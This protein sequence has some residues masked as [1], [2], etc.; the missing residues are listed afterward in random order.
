[1][2]TCLCSALNPSLSPPHCLQG[3]AQIPKCSPQRP[4]QPHSSQARHSNQTHPFVPAPWYS[5]STCGSS[6]LKH[7]SLLFFWLMPWF[8]KLR[9]PLSSFGSLLWVSRN[10]DW[11]RPPNPPL[12]RSLLSVAWWWLCQPLQSAGS[13]LQAGSVWFIFQTPGTSTYL[14]IVGLQQTCVKVRVFQQQEYKVMI[15]VH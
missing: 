5:L 1:M 11:F 3:K 14:I 15:N 10:L 6:S 9:P 7:I 13:C 4:Q 8:S 12:W 2:Q